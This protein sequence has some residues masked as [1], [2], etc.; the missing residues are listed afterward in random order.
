MDDANVPSLLS[1]PYLGYTS[2][3]DP[4]RE[5]EKNTR[6]FVLS[7]D[8]PFY[9][10]GKVAAGVGSPHTWRRYIW[11]IA[12]IMQ[13]LT[14]SDTAEINALVNTCLNTDGG[15]EFMHESFDVDDP[16]RFTRPWFAWANSLF[17]ELIRTKI[18]VINKEP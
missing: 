17:G 13:A 15:R 10:S 11:H 2:P 1:I 5:I 6:K 16:N 14:S 4:D 3:F 7:A 9:Y 12:L 8:N 18:D